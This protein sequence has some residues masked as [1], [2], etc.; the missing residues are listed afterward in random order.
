MSGRWG[1]YKRI[2][3]RGVRCDRCGVEETL[4][5]GRGERMRQIERAVP[6]AQIWFFK[7]LPS[8]MGNLLDVTLRDL[9]KVIYYSNYIV[10]DPGS[11]EV[12]E[13]QLLDED[14]YLTLRQK[15]KAEG[16]TAFQ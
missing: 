5:K 10:V 9:E 8:P 1:N 13:R 12:R 15:A 7:T 14:E 2:R 11:Q 4:S 16:D 6:V 3:C